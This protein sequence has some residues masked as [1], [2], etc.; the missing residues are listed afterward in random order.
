MVFSEKYTYIEASARVFNADP[1]VVVDVFEAELRAAGFQSEL[2]TTTTDFEQPV[3][4]CSLYCLENPHGCKC[5][6]PSCII[7]D[8]GILS[9]L[10]F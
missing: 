3:P 5:V 9:R 10:I 1:V 4:I 8:S 7:N 2:A 6:S